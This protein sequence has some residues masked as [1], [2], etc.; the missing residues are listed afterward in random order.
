MSLSTWFRDY[1]Y[2]PLGGNQVNE[3]RLYINLFIIFFLCG[4]WH[5]AN[6]TFLFWGVLHACYM[7]IAIRAKSLNLKLSRALILDKVPFSKIILLL[8]RNLLINNVFCM[9]ITFALV[10]LGWIFFRA[11]NLNDAF[12][13]TSHLHCGLG[14]FISN[15]MDLSYIRSTLGQLG[16]IKSDFLMMLFLIACII[17]IDIYK[18]FFE[19]KFRFSEQP[20][21]VRWVLYYSI[22]SVVLFYGSFNSTQGF[23]YFQF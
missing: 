10:N 4:L 15:V 12:Y 18:E 16:V 22:V 14:F 19:N 11:E 20:T 2:I 13:I 6:W 8:R 21:W 1:L 7:I 23:I 5:G 9:V 17:A 3:F